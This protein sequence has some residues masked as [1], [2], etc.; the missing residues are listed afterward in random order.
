MDPTFIPFNCSYSQIITTIFGLWILVLIYVH[1]VCI[2]YY[3]QKVYSMPFVLL[4]ATSFVL[5]AAT[6]ISNK[7]IILLKN[8]LF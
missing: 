4:S 7:Q 2:F 1:N 3:S 5:M 6:Y 8:L